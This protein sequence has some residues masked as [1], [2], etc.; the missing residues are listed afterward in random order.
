MAVNGDWTRSYRTVTID[1]RG[2]NAGTPEG[3][4]ALRAAD[5]IIRESQ[6]LG[7]SASPSRA[8]AFN[9]RAESVAS[10]VSSVAATHR[11][12]AAQRAASDAFVRSL[13]ASRSRR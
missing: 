5:S 1:T 10:Q 11:A 9:G 12:E 7:S 8:R 3:Q 4:A 6:S 2:I 13:V